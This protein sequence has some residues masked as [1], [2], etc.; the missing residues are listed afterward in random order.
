[1]SEERR[2]SPASEV[3]EGWCERCSRL[4]RAQRC[5]SCG[6]R[7]LPTSPRDGEEATEE[8]VKAPW[9]FKVL[10]VGTVLYLVYRFIWFIFW[11]FHRAW[12]G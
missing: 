5:P 9:H 12:H 11:L 10:L 6:G 7:L 4:A 2:R 3:A 8:T 1:V